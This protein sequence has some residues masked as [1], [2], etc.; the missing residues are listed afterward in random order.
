MENDFFFLFFPKLIFS[1]LNRRKVYI[2]N[3]DENFLW[4][5]FWNFSEL[6][7]SVLFIK[8]HA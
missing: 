8:I 6:S 5:H 4:N 3:L 1:R 2:S 7:N